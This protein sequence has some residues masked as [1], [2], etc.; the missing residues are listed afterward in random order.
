MHLDK[1]QG[2]P[3]TCGEGP[4]APLEHLQGAASYPGIS[5]AAFRRGAAL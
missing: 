4:L 3:G 1:Q 2:A 5:S